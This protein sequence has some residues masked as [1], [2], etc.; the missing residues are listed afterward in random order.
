VEYFQEYPCRAVSGH[1]GKQSRVKE[2]KR[3]EKRQYTLQIIKYHAWRENCRK[4]EHYFL[5]NRKLSLTCKKKCLI[6]KKT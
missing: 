3:E 5:Q 1:A 2:K 6:R 4:K